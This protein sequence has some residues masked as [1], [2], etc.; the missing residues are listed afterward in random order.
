[1]SV[2]ICIYS[3]LCR[4]ARSSNIGFDHCLPRLSATITVYHDNKFGCITSYTVILRSLMLASNDTCAY[5][6]TCSLTRGTVR[7]YFHPEA[8]RGIRG[9]T[10]GRNRADRG[11]TSGGSA[12][13]ADAA[14][15]DCPETLQAV[16]WAEQKLNL[17]KMARPGVAAAS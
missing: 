5:D 13:D 12:S 15:Y 17:E 4:R 3:P 1:M 16:T 14:T 2:Y 8:P 6:Y 10:S 7:S 11:R 9:T